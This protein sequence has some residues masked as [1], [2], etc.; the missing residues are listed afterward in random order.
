[1]TESYDSSIFSFLRNLHTVFHNGCTN[2]HSHQEYTDAPFSPHPYQ[3]LL[4][5][6]FLMIAILTSMSLYHIVVLICISL[7]IGDVAHLFMGLFGKMFIQFLFGKMSI[8]FF[9]PFLNGFFAFLMLSCM[10]CLY[11]LDINPLLVISFTN[12]FSQ[13][14]S[15]RFILGSLGKKWIH[16]YV[17]LSRFAVHLKLSQH[18]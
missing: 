18:C 11:M 5:M 6:F 1:M 17:W 4:F 16:V 9:C 2:L 12:I 15:C 14:V 7:L 8:L 10:T 3:Q 13:S